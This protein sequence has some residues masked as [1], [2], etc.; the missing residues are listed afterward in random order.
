MDLR[1]KWSVGADE[2][3]FF[4]QTSDVNTYCDALHFRT[5]FQVLL[6]KVWL[7]RAKPR[8]LGQSLRTLSCLPFLFVLPS[9]KTLLNCALFTEVCIIRTRDNRR[10]YAGRRPTPGAKGG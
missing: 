2:S 7:P 5:G 1:C 6:Q 4:V 9:E 3:V 10:R 8:R